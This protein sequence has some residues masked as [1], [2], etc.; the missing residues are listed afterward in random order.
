VVRRPWS[1]KLHAKAP[2]EILHWDLLYFGDSL[3]SSKYLLILKD[4]L[5]HFV[6]L[7]PCDSC[8][9]QVAAEAMLWWVA[10]FGTPS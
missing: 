4:D 6:R 1:E 7:V 5:S 8:T 2:N 3:G 9:A 10:D